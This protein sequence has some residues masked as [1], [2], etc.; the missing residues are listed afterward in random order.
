MNEVGQLDLEL[1]MDALGQSLEQ[2]GYSPKEI[3]VRLIIEAERVGR[4]METEQS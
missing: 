2:H 3:T 1:A 4:E